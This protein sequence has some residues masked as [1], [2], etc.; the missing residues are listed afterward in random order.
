MKTQENT[1]FKY[2]SKGQSLTLIS[3]LGTLEIISR[4]VY[5]QNT[6]RKVMKKGKVLSFDLKAKY[7]HPG[8][9]IKISNLFKN[10][11]IRL[12]T[13]PIHEDKT[14]FEENLRELF[15][16]NCQIT[17]L[18]LEEHNNK[19]LYSLAA[20]DNSK[21]R[22]CQMYGEK[23]FNSGNYYQFEES[24]KKGDKICGF[25]IKNLINENN[26]Q[27]LYV[28]KLY[29]QKSRLKKII[30][31]NF[32]S[33]FGEKRQNK[34]KYPLYFFHITTQYY[35]IDHNF[36]PNKKWVEF[37]NQDQIILLIKQILSPFQ[38][39]QKRS[40]QKNIKNTTPFQKVEPSISSTTSE[41][42]KV[43]INQQ[44]YIS[45]PNKIN[46]GN[47][48]TFHITP[49]F[50][51]ELSK[52]KVVG[53][54]DKKIILAANNQQIFAFDQHAV[55]ERINL[56]QLKVVFLKLKN[57]NKIEIYRLPTEIN[58]TKFQQTK[59]YKQTIIHYQKKLFSIGFE[60]IINENVIKLLTLPI[61]F[62]KI[63]NLEQFYLILKEVQQLK[64][65]PQIPTEFLHILKMKSCKKS[66]KFGDSLSIFQSK[67]LLNQLSNCKFP[68]ICAHGRPL[69]TPLY[70]FHAQVK[71]D[72]LSLNIDKFLSFCKNKKY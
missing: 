1:D 71:N 42:P 28:N 24:N 70:S 41:F 66:I 2:G 48:N 64:T 11:P 72:Q 50:C 49:D 5:S 40:F 39:N 21:N 25:F 32:Q 47:N 44:K 62:G 7:Q 6:Y 52:L 58:I 67:Q 43:F 45:L 38:K 35:E 61:L 34:K 22:F 17:F 27:Y 8:T 46:L 68:Y 18:V 36:Q 13:K 4:S 33:L 12:K 51:L 37:T 65:F 9:K 55:H 57:T 20:T 30:K 54:V 60:I 29:I 19:Y 69:L 14:K 56:E 10:Y 23:Y 16:I 26:F 15:L 31:E 3:Y 53:I 63:I 59:K